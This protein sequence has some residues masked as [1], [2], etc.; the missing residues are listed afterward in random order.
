MRIDAHQHFWKFDPVRDTWITDSM[1]MLRHDFLP[2]SLEP[3]LTRCGFDGCVAVQADQSEQETEFL[4]K[5]AEQHPFIKGVVGWLDLQH[6]NLKDRLELFSENP[7]F[8]G[9]RHIVQAE[10]EG[11]M[12]RDPFL[13]GIDA[14]GSFQLTYDILIYPHQLSET[15]SMIQLF[16]EQKFV[17]DHMAKPY[18]RSKETEQWKEDIS[19]LGQHKNVYCKLSGLVT[20]ATW[21]D[22]IG[23]DFDPYLDSI[24]EA[25]PVSRLI[26]GSDWPVCLV[27]ASYDEVVGLVESYL[28]DRSSNQKEAIMGKNAEY[29]YNL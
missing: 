5:L 22:W 18:I 4:L 26:F 21:N 16:P 11:F 29:F 12:R 2:E 19:L 25:F 9:L 24:F 27:A 7:K 3:H 14:L 15:L 17:I 6:P 8:K 10:P 23:K 28:S 20:E 13:R 1:M